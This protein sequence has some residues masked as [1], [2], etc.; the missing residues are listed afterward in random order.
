MSILGIDIASYQGYPNFG[1]V[2]ASGRSFVITKITEGTGYVNPYCAQNR[3]AA[4]A[5][6]LVVGL[7]HFA[8]ATDPIAEADYFVNSC[9]N[10]VTGEFLMLDW[11]VGA[12]D[13]VGWCKRFLDH[14]FE[15][16][17]V[18]PLIYLNQNLNNSYDWS[19]VVGGDYGLDLAEYDNSTNG[20]VNTDWKTVA[21]KQYT[22]SGQVPGISGNVDLQVFFGDADQLQ[23]YGKQNGVPAP[24]PAPTP[25][26]APQPAPAP[27]ND[28]IVRSG[29]TLSGIASAHGLSLGQIEGFNPQIT[30]PNVIY[31]GQVVHLGGAARPQGATYTVKGGDNLSSI[32][33]SHGY[34]LQHLEQINPQI[35]NPNLIFPGQIINV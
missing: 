17:G 20:T 8:R 3:A 33:S 35:T 28:Y 31:P 10:L 34:S 29:D 21:M 32:A 15:R 24:T 23:K 13:P 11:E 4:H 14:V 26:P 22:S 18:K 12:S 7:Y 27:S 16:T 1:A 2:K 9:G 25:A 6:G 5:A 30:N 19:P